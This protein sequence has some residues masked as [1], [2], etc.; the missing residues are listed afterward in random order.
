MKSIK[1]TIFRRFALLIFCIT[2]LMGV[3]FTIITYLATNYYHQA[4]TELLNKD[5]AAHIAKFTS[6]FTSGGISREKANDVFQNAM[7][8]S[9]ASEVYFLDTTGKV[10][11]FHAPE[12]EIK[13]WHIGLEGIKNYIDT[14][15]EKYIRGM[16]PKDPGNKKIF[17]AAVVQD[18]NRKLGYI[19]VI[20]DSR[21]AENIM[22]LL[23]GSHV[24]RLVIQAFVIIILLSLIF[25]LLY[26]RRISKNFQSMIGVLE[27]FEAGNYSARFDDRINDELQPV[28]HAFNKM[29]SLLSNTIEQLTRSE[30][31]RK[32]F[33]AGIS[34]DLRTPLS[35]ARGYVETL[36]L[37]SSAS[38]NQPEQQQRLQLIHSKV[39]QIEN[40]VAQLF[41]LSKMEAVAFTTNKEPFVLSEIVQESVDGFQA[42]AIEKNIT[43]NCIRSSEH[44]WI[45]ADV[46]MFERVIQNLVENAIKNTEE[47]GCVTVSI[48][49]ENGSVVFKVEN[50]GEKLSLPLL[51]WAN[52]SKETTERIK[53]SQNAGLGLFIVQKILQL[54]N[55]Q[56]QAYSSAGK[57][58]FLFSY[59]IYKSATA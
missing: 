31:E 46:A 19:Y 41:E 28:T 29:A 30:Q 39:L 38:Q 40:M 47:P 27:K 49:A 52:D 32:N 51:E 53:P 36:M 10:I 6:P 22:E 5:V 33:I 17:S 13:A 12:A 14:K 34:H 42:K 1:G 4:S 45:K 18:G 35:I 37:G 25:S 23:F 9:P 2:T 26:V 58:S 7:V 50:D 16:D 15:G 24:M 3:L 55:S 21:K 8:L 43:L 56:L 44:V 11:Y 20:L 54:H 59:P 48:T 57:N